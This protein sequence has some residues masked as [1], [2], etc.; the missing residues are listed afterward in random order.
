MPENELP[1]GMTEGD[2]SSVLEGTEEQAI[3]QSLVP[4]HWVYDNLVSIPW[5]AH[6]QLFVDGAL[7]FFVDRIHEQLHTGLPVWFMPYVGWHDDVEE[8]S[9]ST[10]G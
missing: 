7:R 4:Q 1:G 8:D 9:A 2:G 6:G 10:A 5:R 3:L